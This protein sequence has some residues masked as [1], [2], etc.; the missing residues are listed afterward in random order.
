MRVAGAARGLPAVALRRRARRV[1]PWPGTRPGR[2]ARRSCDGRKEN[3]ITV[4]LIVENLSPSTTESDLVTLFAGVSRVRD[5]KIPT[6]RSTGEPQGFA[7][8]AVASP[9]G[10]E[11]AIARLD[12]YSLEGSVLRIRPA[13][14]E[15]GGPGG[16]R[17]GLWGAGHAGSRPKGSRRGARGRKRGL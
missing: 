3:V 5:V 13:D 16:G 10:A 1:L 15:R 4:Q 11:R 12:G 6:D 7:Y 9:E 17:N 2:R 14:R 8:L